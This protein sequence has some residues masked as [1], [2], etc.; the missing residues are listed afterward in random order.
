M[1]VGLSSRNQQ[2]IQQSG[3]T[4][5][6]AKELVETF[7]EGMD[8][9]GM[10]HLGSLVSYYIKDYQQQEVPDGISISPLNLQ[11][12]FVKLTQREEEK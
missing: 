9:M 1:V 6:G 8:I 4:V 5:S 2:N 11:A 3:A 7:V 10:D 12:Y